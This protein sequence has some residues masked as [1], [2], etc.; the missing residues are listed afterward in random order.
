ME[1]V[2]N[3]EPRQLSTSG[4]NY[5]F[6]GPKTDY[7]G[8]TG[9]NLADQSGNSPWEDLHSKPIKYSNTNFLWAQ[10]RKVSLHGC[11]SQV[12]PLPPKLFLSQSSFWAHCIT[13]TDFTVV[14]GEGDCDLFSTYPDMPVLLGF[15]FCLG[16]HQ[17]DQSSGNGVNSFCGLSMNGKMQTPACS[18]FLSK[19]RGHLLS[20]C[21]QG[22]LKLL[23]SPRCASGGG[24]NT[25]S[26]QWRHVRP[27]R[28]WAAL[29][30]HRNEAQREI[31]GTTKAESSLTYEFF[32]LFRQGI[33]IR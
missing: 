1:Y 11:M 23:N 26:V 12:S 18:L 17:T 4:Y 25:F 14:V 19:F 3:S 15:L 8:T 31:W 9:G 20:V 28:G 16:R 24:E 13:V 5:T 7:S 10:P 2:L 29:L 32:L 6:C 22:C 27:Q 30:Q 21:D 33:R